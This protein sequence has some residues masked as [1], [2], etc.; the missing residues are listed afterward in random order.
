MCLHKS[1]V[2][3][4]SLFEQIPVFLKKILMFKQ[5]FLD[6]FFQLFIFFWAFRGQVKI[7]MCINAS[8]R[9]PW[10]PSS[11]YLV[12]LLGPVDLWV[13]SLGPLGGSFGPLGGS[14]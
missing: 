14:A 9:F 5:H 3:L 7:R 6:F 13:G 12:P 8:I 2:I 4:L 1:Q 10:V 11:P